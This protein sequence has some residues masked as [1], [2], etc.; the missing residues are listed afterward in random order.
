MAY[1]NVVAILLLELFGADWVHHHRPRRH[2]VVTSLGQWVVVSGLPS[3]CQEEDGPVANGRM[4]DGGQSAM[5]VGAV[6]AGWP[7][8]SAGL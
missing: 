4:T 7:Q 6:R 2:T 8:I 1:F 3:R 5:V